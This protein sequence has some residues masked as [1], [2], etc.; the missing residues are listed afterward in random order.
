MDVPV[1]YDPATRPHEW[2]KHTLLQFAEEDKEVPTAKPLE[3]KSREELLLR[4]EENRQLLVDAE[5]VVTPPVPWNGSEGKQ[6]HKAIA[7]FGLLIE[8]YECQFWW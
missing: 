5:I 3:E 4:L 6:E 2:F 7:H 1:D 8:A